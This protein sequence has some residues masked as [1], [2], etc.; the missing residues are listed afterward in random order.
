MI[1]EI[2]RNMIALGL[3]N[4]DLARM[5]PSNI[6]EKDLSQIMS[7]KR[8]PSTTI[9]EVIARAMGLEWKLTKRSG[10]ITKEPKSHDRGV[11]RIVN[12]SNAGF[13]AAYWASKTPLERLSALELLRKQMTTSNGI[14]QRL[15]RI[16]S[17]TKRT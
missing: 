13:D 8:K 7:G 11:I 9:L 17:V 1:K 5:L 2:K 10:K 6:R 15:Q 4:A 12:K 3:N 14:E 16:Y